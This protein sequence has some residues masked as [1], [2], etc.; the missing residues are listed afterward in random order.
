MSRPSS[1]S[2][3]GVNQTLPFRI[4]LAR[5]LA[6][7]LLLTM[8]LM[9]L[10]GDV[11]VL[12]QEGDPDQPFTISEADYSAIVAGL[13]HTCALLA[14]GHVLCWGNTAQGRTI[15]PGDVFQSISAGGGHN[16]GV[17]QDGTVACWGWR[18]HGQTTPPAGKFDF[19]G[20]GREHS[21]GLRTNQ[22]I[23]CWG[24]DYQGVVEPPSGAFNFLGVGVHHNCAIK[25]SGSLACWGLN[26]S[27][28][29]TPPSGLFQFVSA[30]F[31]HSCGIL[32]D[33]TLR[34]WGA[35][36]HGKTTPPA[37]IFQS[38]SAGYGNT[39]GLRMDGAIFC[40]GW[41]NV[42]QSF[43]PEG[44]FRS[45][46]TRYGHTCAVRADGAALCWG[47]KD[48]HKLDFPILDPSRRIDIPAEP[49]VRGQ[50]GDYWADVIIGKPDFSEIVPAE[51]TPF[52]VFNPGGVYVDRSVDP[53]FVYVWDAGNSRILGMDLAGCYGS[54][55][56]CHADI[57]LGQPSLYDHA[58]CNGD[59]GVQ[60]YPHRAP[61]SASTL[62]GIPDLSLSPWEAK[63]FVNM[64]IDPMR[65]LYTPDSFN[66]RVLFYERPFEEDNVADAVWGQG[67][68][69][70][71]NCNRGN[72]WNPSA[73]TLCFHSASNHNR[74][75][76]YNGWPA[77]GVE[78]DPDGNLWIA[79]S[80]NNRVLRFPFD[81]TIGQPRD[82]A[83]LVLGQPDFY[84]R[85][86]G[87]GLQRLFAPGALR[88]GPNGRLYVA[89]TYN[90][91]V[92]V[93][94]PPFSSGM[95]VDL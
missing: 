28:Q 41:N 53:G 9:W 81:R 44:S 75:P 5:R 72:H 12:G 59:S 54:E 88:F 36:D 91:R 39:C 15:P 58:A 16:C 60:D 83:D 33:G 68:F 7:A 40:W 13:E 37:G 22:S 56:P 23:Q 2:H 73:K 67:D 29:A 50:V 35:N 87:Q 79:D 25:T 71:L 55:S 94:D 65:N 42:G 77:G 78:L 63:S 92:V 84:H 89:D 18:D 38:V 46:S 70:G 52:K 14:D 34:C 69:S 51:V 1:L 82:T 90:N 24:R 8:V 45:V 10:S 43:S 47:S 86:T 26:D 66:N 64:V 19:V 74:I 49:L 11:P 61:A 93:F 20:A 17:R 27:G 31:T 21:C 57:V 30:G 95:A 76:A 80:G 62:C 48:S 85:D 32:M 3:R 4:F 6:V